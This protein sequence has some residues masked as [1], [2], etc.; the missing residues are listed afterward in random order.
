MCVGG[1]G[2]GVT[3]VLQSQNSMGAVSNITAM[4]IPSSHSV[5]NYHGGTSVALAHL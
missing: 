1:G 3:W 5:G 2:G 4:V